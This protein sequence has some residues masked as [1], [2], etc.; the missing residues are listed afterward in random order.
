MEV[1]G[2]VATL[3]RRVCTLESQMNEIRCFLP[4]FMGFLTSNEGVSNSALNI[5]N[6][7]SENSTTKTLTPCES[8]VSNNAVVETWDDSFMVEN[9]P[10]PIFPHQSVTS[11][12]CKNDDEEGP[13][14][15]E[16]GEDTFTHFQLRVNNDCNGFCSDTTTTE[17]AALNT[18]DGVSSSNDIFESPDDHLNSEQQPEP[19]PSH[20]E[21]EYHMEKL[22]KNL[23][24]FYPSSLCCVIDEKVQDRI[25]FPS[26]KDAWVAPPLEN[27]IT[28]DENNHIRLSDSI[29]MLSAMGGRDGFGLELGRM[30]PSPMTPCFRQQQH[31]S[32][33]VRV[34]VVVLLLLNHL[35]CHR[36]RRIL[37]L[38]FLTVTISIM[39]AGFHVQEDAVGE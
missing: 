1:D 31:A 8:I 24:P 10:S 25:N 30:R 14:P 21:K 22:K 9:A 39:M 35:S 20:A 4:K 38:H 13:P 3:L 2:V 36:H 23:N 18:F 15:Y 34:S 12:I 11:T 17:V 37:L 7:K 29:D 5:F 16:N 27:S 26:W 32:V 28:S 6:E 33:Q 19:Q